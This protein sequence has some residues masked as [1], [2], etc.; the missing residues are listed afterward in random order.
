MGLALGADDKV[1]RFLIDNA[2][3]ATDASTN[4]HCSFKLDY[5]LVA[6]GAPVATYMPKVARLLSTKLS[7][8]EHCGLANAIGAVSGSVVQTVRLLIQPTDE[9]ERVRLHLPSGVEEY[10]TLEE[11]LEVARTLGR[12]LA[13]ERVRLAG[14][15]EFELNIEQHDQRV[16][17]AAGW[18]DE[19]YLGSE[20]IITAAGRPALV[21]RS[22]PA[23][24]TF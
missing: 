5:H 22:A 2:L 15:E 13:T 7:I 10:G 8:P 3:E 1:G 9:G 11:G 6:I 23:P 14:A 4:L 17:V 21:K 12:A 18:G 16:Q 20:L 19:I 24:T